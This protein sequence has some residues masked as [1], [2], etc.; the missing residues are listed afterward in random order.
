MPYQLLPWRARWHP[1]GAEGLVARLPSRVW[2]LGRDDRKAGF[3]WD[4]WLEPLHMAPPGWT[5]HSETSYLVVQGSQNV[6]EGLGRSC[7]YMASDLASE[8]S[9]SYLPHPVSWVTEAN[10][11]AQGVELDS[12]YQWEKKKQIS[13][14]GWSTLQTTCEH[15]WWYRSS[16]SQISG[17]L[18]K[19]ITFCYLSC[20]MQ[21][22]VCEL[23]I[24]YQRVCT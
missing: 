5:W 20:H 24:W 21:M 11:D 9:E 10:P 4:C 16:L 1:A 2:C 13:S 18:Q 23:N 17:F 22:C 6:Q 15:K 19:R 8:V 7:Y 12:I 14:H 3:K